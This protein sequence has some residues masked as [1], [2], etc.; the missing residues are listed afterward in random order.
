M[1]ERML[2]IG[3]NIYNQFNLNC[4]SV[5]DFFYVS[6]YRNYGI[7]GVIGCIDGSH[8]KIV[9]PNK[10]EEHLYYSRKHYHSLNVQMVIVST[11]ICNSNID[12]LL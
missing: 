2:V 12:I 3:N 8:F 4:I 5:H 6:F 7:P 10:E 9:V 1:Q 11:N